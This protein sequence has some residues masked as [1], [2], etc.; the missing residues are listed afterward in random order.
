MENKY[1]TEF[2]N[3]FKSFENIFDYALNL[4]T[5]KKIQEAKDFYDTYREL[6]K[7]IRQHPIE[8]GKSYISM[9]LSE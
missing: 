1:N 6:E 8:N 9:F 2:F 4:I 7:E 5:D 3:S